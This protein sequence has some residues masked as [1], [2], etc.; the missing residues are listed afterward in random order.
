MPGGAPAVSC[1]WSASTASAFHSYRLSREKP[2][3]SRVVVFTSDNRDTT[4]YVDHDVQ[5]GS[6]YSYWIEVLDASGTVIAHG[7]AATVSCC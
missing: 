1:T 4:S 6:G 7:S 3:T 5:A 2:G